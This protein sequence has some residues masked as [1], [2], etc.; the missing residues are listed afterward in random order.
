QADGQ[1]RDSLV[2]DPRFVDPAPDDYRLKP[3]SPAFQLGFQ[4]IPV[5]QIGCYQDE[6]RASWPV[7]EEENTP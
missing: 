4:P 7:V 1:D 5:E 3:D 6:L 2:A